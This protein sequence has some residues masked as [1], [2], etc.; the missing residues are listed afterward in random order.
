MPVRFASSPTFHGGAFICL[1]LTCPSWPRQEGKA[2]RYVRIKGGQSS[3]I[4]RSRCD[5][6]AHADLFH[7]MRVN[8]CSLG[9]R[10]EGRLADG[11]RAVP[12]NPEPATAV[13]PNLVTGHHIVFGEIQPD[14]L[15]R[16]IQQNGSVHYV[17]M[18]GLGLP[19][20]QLMQID[21]D[22]VHHPDARGRGVHGGECFLMWI[23][24]VRR[25]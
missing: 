15:G 14:E 16:E 4:V 24:L 3:S 8:R 20:E 7:D 18:H 10:R 11:P 25:E 5:E 23:V 19:L 13:S 9:R 17:A 6:H 1:L 21:R 12:W 2:S 22:D